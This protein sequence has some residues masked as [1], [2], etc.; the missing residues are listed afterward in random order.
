MTSNVD[1]DYRRVLSNLHLIILFSQEFGSSYSK[2]IKISQ[3]DLA[4][5]FS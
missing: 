5:L 4:K 1:I 3:K 2:K